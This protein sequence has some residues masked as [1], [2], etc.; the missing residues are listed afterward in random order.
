M[1]KQGREYAPGDVWQAEDLYI[2]G[3][4]TYEQVSRETGIPAVT[5][6]RWAEKYDWRGRREKYRRDMALIRTGTVELKQ[7]LLNTAIKTLDGMENLSSQELFGFGNLARA[8]SPR[9]EGRRSEA[10][11][12]DIDRPA[13][14][15]ADLE[16]VARVLEEIDPEGLK[17]LGRNFDALVGR[18]KAEHEKAA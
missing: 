14:F 13:L 5:L 18:F 7:R 3:G 11:A 2:A 8:L 4:L 17:V 15:L 10:R 16:F 9:D 12:A 6:Q 1:A